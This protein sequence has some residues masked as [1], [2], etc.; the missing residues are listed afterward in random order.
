MEQAGNRKGKGASAGRVDSRR[1]R[2]E[3]RRDLRFELDQLE[4]KLE[5]L[6][7]EYEQ[8]FLGFR[9]YAPDKQHQEIK[10]IIR[11]LMS[12][13]FKNSEINYR[14][15]ALKHRHSTYN[16]YWQRVNKQ[17]EE[18]TYNRDVF[19]AN[20]RERFALEDAKAET[21]QGQAQGQMQALYNSYKRELEKQTGKTQK[22]DYQAFQK[23]LVK[24]AKEYKKQHGD[25][26]L[27]FKVVVQ[28]GKVSVRAKAKE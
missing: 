11:S 9:P 25:K 4:H 3:E 8:F 17:R 18:G 12:A 10:R 24:R 5:S 23:S 7:T 6:K 20:M 14:I 27:S 19:K 22:L 1:E 26:K 15:R 2:V 16:T 13:P 28:N 21:K